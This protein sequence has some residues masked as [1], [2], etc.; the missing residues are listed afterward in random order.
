MNFKQAICYFLSHTP[1][2]RFRLKN[3]WYVNCTRC[4]KMMHDYPAKVRVSKA[5]VK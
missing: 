2:K 3:V 5:K 4:G 1:S